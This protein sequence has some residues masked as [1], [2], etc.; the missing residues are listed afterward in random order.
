MNNQ[1]IEP[2]KGTT[3]LAMRYNGGVVLA[4]DNRVTMGHMIISKVDKVFP[5]TEFLAMTTAGTVSDNQVILK[6]LQAEMKLYELESSKKATLENLAAVLQNIIYSGFKSYQPFMMQNIIAGLTKD[7]SFRLR[8]LDPSGASIEDPYTA[9]GSGMMF[10]LGLMQDAY[11]ENMSESEAV[12]LAVRS[13]HSAIRR[14]SASG[15]GI[16]IAVI[17]KKGYRRL[18][19]KNISMILNE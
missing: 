8:S 4:T 15:D 19:D 9:T 11:K 7:G 12:D 2:K 6:H 3:T 1:K 16:S 5:I 13:I 14:D 18:P 17:D 10:V